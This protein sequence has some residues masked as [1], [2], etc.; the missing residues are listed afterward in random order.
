MP[1]KAKPGVDDVKTLYPNLILDW[2]Y[3]KNE[4]LPEMYLPHSRKRINWKCHVC[5]Y[6]WTAY[7]YSRVYGNGCPACAGQRVIVGKN[8]LK[9]RRPDIAE[10]WDYEANGNLRPEN[11][12]VYSGK[13]VHWKCAKGHK[14]VISPN[15]RVSQN[16]G[17]ERCSSEL[18]TS[19]SEQAILYYIKK[20]CYAE[21]RV[22]IEGKELDIFIPAINLAV[23]YDGIYFHSGK[24]AE[25]REKA[26]NDM[27]NRKKI[28]LLRVK[29]CRE[30]TVNMQDVFYRLVGK[31][32]N[33]DEAINWVINIVCELSNIDNILTINT[34]KDR[35]AILESYRLIEKEHSLEIRN[36]EI[37]LEW[38]PTLNGILKPSQFSYGSKTV[39]WWKCQK[40]HAYTAAIAHRTDENH[41]T[42]C[43]YCSGQKILSGYNDLA[44]L[45]P[46]LMKDWDYT[47]NQGINP[48]TISPNSSLKVGWICSKQHKYIAT[49]HKR[50]NG[51]NCP[52]CSNKKVWIGYNDLESQRPDIAVDWD[53]DNNELKPTEVVSGC[54]KKINWK[55]HVCGERWTAS[56]N[57]RTQGKGKCKKCKNENNPKAV[58][59][60]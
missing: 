41:Q 47:V 46:D 3:S 55:C 21:N 27:C 26:K 39:V 52:Y 59:K 56:V 20:I 34:E 29:E 45:R 54:N 13:K 6:E 43:P 58:P 7:L 9:T 2:D 10:E 50:N 4:R 49:P 28:R 42:G 11:I 19:F 16:T 25:I 14:W 60:D 8:D 22:K 1:K 35:L 57:A 32:S 33:L 36:P 53:Y 23:E 51:R 18:R 12:A 37:A 5:G 44:T 24:E 48:S 38:H 40:G 17:C 31:N 15:S 30:K